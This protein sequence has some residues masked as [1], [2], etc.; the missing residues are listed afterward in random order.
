ME[1][2]VIY[3]RYSSHNQTEQSIEGQIAAGHNYADNHKY[4]VIGEYIDRAKS[5]TNDNR[6]E[7]QKMLKDASKKTFSVIIVWKVDRFGRN[8]EEITF[9]KHRVK[10][11]GVRVE[12]V[13]ENITKGPEG[14][15]LESVLEG[16]AE[17]YSLQLSQNVKRGL[18]ESAKKHRVINPAKIT[19]GYRMDEDHKYVIDPVTAP[20]VKEIY[21]K[22]K[23]GYTI[24]EII[25]HFKK[26]G[27]VFTK[28]R[29]SGILRNE[30]YTG[31]YLYKDI[32]R[33]EDAIPAII[34]KATFLEVQ[35]ML[36][37]HKRI[38]SKNW[39]HT[40]YLFTDKIFCGEC[41]RSMV[42][43][44]GYSHMGTKYRYYTCSGRKKYKS[45]SKSPIPKEELEDKVINHLLEILKDE[46]IIDE[47]VDAVWAYYL[48][49]KDEDKERIYLEDALKKVN[50]SITNIMKAIE[51]GLDYSLAK[52]RLAALNTKK[53]ELETDLANKKI[54][55]GPE[56]TKEHIKFFLS[57]VLKKDTTDKKVL[58][59]IINTFVN[60]IYVFENRIEVYLN[61]GY[62]TDFTKIKET[63]KGST[64]SVSA[65][66][67]LQYPN[68]FISLPL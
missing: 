24:T 45:C 22:Y 46:D 25:N 50:S 49:N 13:A 23:S 20:I 26:H 47:I 4:N 52:D 48:K 29:I 59:N 17:Y 64:L 38:P 9:N 5:G 6:E 14:V 61:Y 3:A 10:K 55:E 42:G 67:Y 11:Y 30:R 33:D 27:Y 40:E 39:E 41:G 65:G 58:E 15:I 28:N 8:R 54:L 21:E 32:I 16:M 7:F 2:A 68:L 53:E 51:D 62:N 37:I 43:E 34:D 36:K 12:Y 31:V 60:R 18:L 1:N 19:F 66:L 56:L 44:S 35:K 63:D 57:Y